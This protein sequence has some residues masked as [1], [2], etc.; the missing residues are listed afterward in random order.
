MEFEGQLDLLK[1]SYPIARKNATAIANYQETYD[2]AV[3]THS[4]LSNPGES[5][6]SSMLS[7]PSRFPGTRDVDLDKKAATLIVKIEQGT[8]L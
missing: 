3:L 4:Y 5:G 1:Q 2:K 6:K 8:V 7:V